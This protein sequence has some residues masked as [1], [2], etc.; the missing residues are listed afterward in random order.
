MKEVKRKG[1]IIGLTASTFD[2]LHAGHIAMLREAKQHCDWLIVGLLSD[3]TIDRP[4]TK[5]K[6]IQS[7]FERHMQLQ[8][9]TYID[10]IIPFESEQDLLDMLLV[11]MPNVRFCG[12]E[13][14]DVDH[15]GKHIE[16]IKI[17]YNKRKHS[18][19]SSELRERVTRA[20]SEPVNTNGMNP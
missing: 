16:G 13:Y 10:E 2:L 19:S 20:N 5:N 7:L 9:I 11:L 14:K 15:T 1:K 6:P 12:E 3:P 4:D 8:A 18:F 17:H